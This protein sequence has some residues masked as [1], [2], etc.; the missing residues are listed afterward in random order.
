M[1]VIWCPPRIRCSFAAH[2][3]L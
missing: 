3:I 2:G 1:S